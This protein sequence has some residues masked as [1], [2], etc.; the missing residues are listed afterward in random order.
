MQIALMHAWQGKE[1]RNQRLYKIQNTLTI[2]MN[3]PNPQCPNTS[4]F[5][6]SLSL[7]LM[8]ETGKTERKKKKKCVPQ[9]LRRER[10]WE[11]GQEREGWGSIKKG[12][13]LHPSVLP[14]KQAS[15]GQRP[16]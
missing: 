8:K 9:K 11:K 5:P 6:L 15:P 10:E 1:K 2:I 13:A 12:E 3:G 14:L 7:K 4:R 16:C